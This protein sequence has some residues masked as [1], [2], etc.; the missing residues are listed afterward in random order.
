MGIL[1]VACGLRIQTQTTRGGNRRNAYFASRRTG[2]ESISASRLR[3]RKRSRIARLFYFLSRRFLL[4]VAAV[5]APVDVV[6]ISDF[7]FTKV[8][9][10]CK[11]SLS[12]RER[13]PEVAFG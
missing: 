4:S 13:K 10:A 8:S 3:L 2:T 6:I 12:P 11:R 1:S 5:V 7:L 9:S